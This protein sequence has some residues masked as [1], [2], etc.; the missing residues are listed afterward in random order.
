VHG[1]PGIVRSCA[2]VSV[3]DDDESVR[4]SLPDLLREVGYAVQVYSSAE[5]FLGSERARDTHCLILDIFLQGMSGPELIRE[6][7]ARRL[8][9]PIIFVTA[10][11]D[12]GLRFR[13]IGEGAVECLFKPF[14][15]TALVTALHAALRTGRLN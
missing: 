4:E 5:E 9:V 13:L 12:E 6:L 15:D 7:A 11:V 2:F 8:L 3:V 14:S 10:H 1:E